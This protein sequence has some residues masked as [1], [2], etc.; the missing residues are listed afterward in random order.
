MSVNVKM[1][2]NYKKKYV[3]QKNVLIINN[4]MIKNLKYVFNVSFLAKLAFQ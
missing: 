3:L 2:I 4:F 1:I